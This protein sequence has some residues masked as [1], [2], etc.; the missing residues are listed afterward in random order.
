M[1]GYKERRDYLRRDG[2][3]VND[4]WMNSVRFLENFSTTLFKKNIVSLCRHCFAFSSFFF[5]F[6]FLLENFLNGKK[7][8]SIYFLFSFLYNRLYIYLK[9]LSNVTIN[10]HTYVYTHIYI[11]IKSRSWELIFEQG[12]SVI[13]TSHPFAFSDEMV[14]TQNLYYYYYIHI[15]IYI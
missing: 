3:I 10:Q 9:Q 6:L 8:L 15:Y 4:R 1:R 13:S 2:F 12:D 5:L 7:T 14:L 11:F